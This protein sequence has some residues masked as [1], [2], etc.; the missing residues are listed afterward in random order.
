MGVMPLLEVQSLRGLHQ[1][2][3]SLRESTSPLTQLLGLLV[4]LQVTNFQ[5]EKVFNRQNFYLPFLRFANYDYTFNAPET[6]FA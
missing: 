3:L 1:R 2:S 5:W 6:D 4:V